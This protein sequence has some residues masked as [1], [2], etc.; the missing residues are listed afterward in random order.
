[1][2][3]SLSRLQPFLSLLS[4]ILLMRL[5]AAQAQA[6]PAFDQ[7]TLG[8]VPANATSEARIHALVADAQGNT[9]L[10]G[11]V[12]GTVS[13]GTTTFSSVNGNAALFVAK[14]N[15]AGQFVWA[16][17]AP[18]ADCTALA[19][20]GTGGVLVAGGFTDSTLV[21]GP[22]ILLLSSAQG[23]FRGR[24]N[25]FVAKMSAAS[26]TW[27]WAA[28]AGGNR[29]VGIDL[30]TG[31]AVDGQGNAV[32]TGNL[33]SPQ[34]RFGNRLVVDN[35]ASSFTDIFVAKL[36][37]AGNWLWAVGGGGRYDEIATAVAVAPA[38]DVY[39]LAHLYRGFWVDTVQ[40]LRGGGLL[41]AKLDAFGQWEWFVGAGQTTSA[42]YVP[43]TSG[44]I[45]PWCKAI[46]ADDRAVYLGGHVPV[47]PFTVLPLTLTGLT[48]K[49]VVAR[50]DAASGA[51]RWLLNAA[52]SGGSEVSGLTFSRASGRL[53]GSGV[54]GGGPPGTIPPRGSVFGPSSL[55]GQG[56]LDALV[57]EVD[58]A[59]AWRW[60]TGGGSSNREQFNAV[61]PDGLGRLHLLGEA[62]PGPA[63]YG[64]FSLT[65][66]PTRYS[67]PF[68]FAGSHFLARVAGG[69]L[70]A[71]AG[72]AAAGFALYP[73][74]SHGQAWVTGLPAGQ[75]VEV[76]DV[77]GRRLLAARAPGV[78]PCLL[79]LPASRPTGI[80]LVRAGTHTLRWAVE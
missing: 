19:L 52:G 53:F 38:G 49:A 76:C 28:Q 26:G 5:P 36:D 33:D 43:G 17:S 11:Y 56:F 2:I 51:C 40:V 78:G 68:Y 66:P 79:T 55:A 1:M 70:A 73:N 34:M 58:T 31:L 45:P 67:S 41:V 63:T 54:F 57:M 9:Y 72:R 30:C 24:P 69:P 71:V 42:G 44:L 8:W 64:P 32:I 50:L 10:A 39:V 46:A 77:L 21:L 4:F 16:V 47:S 74:P 13:F 35:L 6:V 25:I 29:T 14:R 3:R 75:A 27:Q 18:K 62:A 37:P 61:A 48:G 7:A 15:A 12:E 80:Y 20:D 59:G 23:S 22:T 65:L 60:A